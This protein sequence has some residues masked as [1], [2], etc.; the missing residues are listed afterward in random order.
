[1]A[2]KADS[3]IRRARAKACAQRG[4][5]SKGLPWGG[6]HA[7]AGQTAGG[8]TAFGKRASLEDVGVG[9]KEGA[10]ALRQDT[11][12]IVWIAK[13]LIISG[14][15]GQW[16]EYN[17]KHHLL[18]L[19]LKTRMDVAALISGWFRVFLLPP[20]GLFVLLVVGW[21]MRRRWP[22]TGK[23]VAR[24]ALLLFFVLCTPVGADLLVA[25]LENL[26]IPLTPAAARGAQAIVVLAAGR[27]DNAPEYADADIPDYIALARLRYGAKLQHETGLPVL[28]S[29]GNRAVSA[30]F[31]SK[32]EDMAIA[33]AE[34]FLTPVTWVEDRSET[35]AEN[36]TRSGTILRAQGIQRILLV[37]DAMH[38]PR[39]EK[40]FA[41]SGL[42]VMAAPTMFFRLQRHDLSSFIPSAEGLRRSY[43]AMY[44]WI[45][46]LWYRLRFS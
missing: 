4:T 33:M 18:Q 7:G 21:L 42:N 10:S 32:A 38:M 14:R 22:R 37:T 46:I 19:T 41:Q 27:L 17:A 24:S 6:N 16:S 8:V 28:V 45:G 31:K 26:T 43:Y 30:P 2:K 35:T 29:G 20:A 25:P 40:V 1:M 13:S 5:V 36:A 44:E 39:A 3:R 11:S 15:P 23:V 34:D 12:P 9:H